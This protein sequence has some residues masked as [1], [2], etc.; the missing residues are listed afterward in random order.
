MIYH[1]KL[2]KIFIVVFF[3]IYLELRLSVTQISEI[4]SFWYTNFGNTEKK[5]K[6]HSNIF[7]S[8]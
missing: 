3:F 2:Y 4:G 5:Q 8:I 6:N 7:L 1:Q